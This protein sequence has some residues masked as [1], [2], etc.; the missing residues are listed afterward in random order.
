MTLTTHPCHCHLPLPD[1][2]ADAP[3]PSRPAT[4]RRQHDEDDTPSPSPDDNATTRAH[5]SSPRPDTNTD[6]AT[7]RLC[8]RHPHHARPERGDRSDG[9]TH[10]VVCIVPS[11]LSPSLPAHTRGGLP[12]GLRPPTR[13]QTRTL[14]RGT[15]KSRVRVRVALSQ[16]VGYPCSCLSMLGWS[17]ATYGVQ[18]RFTPA[19]ANY[20]GDVVTSSGHH[21]ILFGSL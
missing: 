19:E 14:G 7:T 16:P 17:M 20:W 9:T 11:L 2:D 1:N 8:P 12:M 18:I 21:M 10:I 6:N 15:G 13:M 3:S 4:I 5:R